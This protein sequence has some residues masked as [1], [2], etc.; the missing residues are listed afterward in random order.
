V[1]RSSPFLLS[2]FIFSCQPVDPAPSDA[3][4][5]IVAEDAGTPVDAGVVDAGTTTTT[6]TLTMSVGN[7]T[8][9]FTRAQHGLEPA[10]GLYVEAHFGG[11]PAC[12]TQTSPTPDRTL[13]ISGLQPLTDGGV[14][15]EADGV[16]VTLLDFTGALTTLPALKATT[17]RATA[18]E[19]NPGVR[20]AFA[21]EATFDGGT[22]TGTFSAE[23]CT[24]LD[25]P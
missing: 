4:V 18:R 22:L 23:H 20:V 1:L 2:L 3:G 7:K 17:V 16:R 11:A 6:T 13:I 19:M 10:G 15:T 5:T 14:M 25:G 12:P 8:G 21:L 9:P 24:S